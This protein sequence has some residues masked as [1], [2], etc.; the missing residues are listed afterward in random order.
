[1]NDLIKYTIELFVAPYRS[2]KDLALKIMFLDK[3]NIEIFMLT[4]VAIGVLS[5]VIDAVVRVLLGIPLDLYSGYLPYIIRIASIV[6]MLI[7]YFLFELREPSIYK[8]L[9]GITRNNDSSHSDIDNRGKSQNDVNA[10]EFDSESQSKHE[11]VYTD[12]NDTFIHNINEEKDINIYSIDINDDSDRC[13]DDDLR[14]RTEDSELVQYLDEL[15]NSVEVLKDGLV[16][17]YCKGM[18]EDD[19]R[20]LEDIF[21][22][23]DEDSEV[24]DDEI[25]GILQGRISED[26]M[27]LDTL[28]SWGIPDDFKM[29]S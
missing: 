12:E 20:E 14:I 22:S 17:N 5:I 21:E 24:F 8:I 4:S 15:N 27:T 13:F 25:L 3:V 1:M 9:E 10:C 19:L 16:N 18:T 29:L 23:H 6:L 11:D 28:R 2:I 7:V 26:I